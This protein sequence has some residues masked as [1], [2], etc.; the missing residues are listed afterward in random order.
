MAATAQRSQ[1][2]IGIAAEHAGNDMVNVAFFQRNRLIAMD[3]FA[4][5]A[6]PYARA[7]A[8]SPYL[9]RLPF[10]WHGILA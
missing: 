3:T 1:V 6:L 4:P 2:V 8:V 9:S 7:G 10:P 5:I